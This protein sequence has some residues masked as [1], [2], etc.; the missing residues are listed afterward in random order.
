MFAMLVLAS[1]DGNAFDL[2]IAAEMMYF[3]YEETDISGNVINQETGFIPGLS[4]SAAQAFNSV[5]NTFKISA[6]DG[7]VDYDGQTQ[8]GLPHET[9]TEETIYRMLYKLSWSPASSQSSLYGEAGWQQWDRDIQPTNGV[10]GLFERYRWWSLEAGIQLPFIKSDSQ[11][12]SLQLGMLTTFNGTIMIDLT[13][14]GY[15]N[16]TLDLGD[17]FGFSGELNYRYRQARHSSLQL[18]LQ[19]RTW[20]FG[21]S[22]SKI[23]TNGLVF[24]SIY[25]PD[26]TTVQTTLSASYIH[27]F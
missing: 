9:T 11:D 25:E 23:I 12:L 2:G 20:D 1:A 14:A 7:Q 6:Y 18:G 21:K 22:N 4:L 10:L 26:S 27:H 17:D 19:V 16:H 3:D 15:G 13:E 24:K 8:S 5:N